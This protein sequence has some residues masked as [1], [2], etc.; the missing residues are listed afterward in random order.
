M[1]YIGKLANLPEYDWRTYI[2]GYEENDPT[3]GVE[4]TAPYLPEDNS[5]WLIVLGILALLWLAPG[6]RRPGA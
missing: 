5:T 2:P 4:V 3:F 1:A 6:K